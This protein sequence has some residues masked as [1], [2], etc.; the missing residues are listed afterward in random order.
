MHWNPRFAD[1]LSVT[2]WSLNDEHYVEDHTAVYGSYFP[3]LN[4]GTVHAGVAFSEWNL[5]LGKV[6]RR[7]SDR[8]AAGQAYRL[9]RGWVLYERARQQPWALYGFDEAYQ[10]IA[11][12]APSIN[13]WSIPSTFK[14]RAAFGD[15][16]WK[17]TE[18]FDLAGGIR[19]ARDTQSYTS[20][21]RAARSTTKLRRP[22]LSSFAR[23]SANS[24]MT[25]LSQREISHRTQAVMVYGR[26]ATGSQPA[27]LSVPI[28]VISAGPPPEVGEGHQL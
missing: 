9:G 1:V 25:W 22:P 15:V 6:F 23:S 3:L 21:V 14:E 20:V 17:L 18:Y 26:V 13:F 2:G 28:V 27:R 4:S 12:F 5:D 24:V 11:A 8:L 16:T 7:A 19:F 10:P